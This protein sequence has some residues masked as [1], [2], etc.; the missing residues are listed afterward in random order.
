MI[1][2]IS[3]LFFILFASIVLLAYTVIPHH[4]HD[5]VICIASSHC[6]PGDETDFLKT[7]A[8]N[9]EHDGKI[10]FEY[11]ILQQVIVV[12][13]D[14]AKLECKCL[15]CVDNQLQ[16]DGFQTV[17][18]DKGLYDLFP[19]ISSTAEHLLL[20]STYTYFTGTGLGLRAPPVV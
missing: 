14:Q 18:F 7:T 16:F 6:Q 11:C 15:N 20:S 13:S 4:H 10:N 17:L 12:P 8:N 19:A 9:H 3:S 1:N 2:R 5:G